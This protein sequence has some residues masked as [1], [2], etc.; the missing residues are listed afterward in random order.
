MDIIR[1]PYESS[2]SQEGHQR[3]ATSVYA[4]LRYRAPGNMLMKAELVNKVAELVAGRGMTHS[5][6][7]VRTFGSWSDEGRIRA[8]PGAV[9][10]IAGYLQ[11]HQDLW[12]LP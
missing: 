10:V 5:Q 8:A 9:S 6:S 2:F 7:S 12:R 11:A 3:G 1:S 4:D